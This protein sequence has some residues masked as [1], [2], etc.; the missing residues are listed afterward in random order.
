MNYN[1]QAK[2]ARSFF[3]VEICHHPHVSF[4]KSLK[5]GKINSIVGFAFYRND[6]CPRRGGIQAFSPVNIYFE[7]IRFRNYS[8]N[9]NDYVTA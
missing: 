3:S 2:S 5:I 9:N 4:I 8:V 1:I 7:G 6:Y